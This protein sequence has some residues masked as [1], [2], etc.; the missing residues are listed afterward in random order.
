MT[1]KHTTSGDY[2]GQVGRPF[3]ARRIAQFHDVLA[4][5]GQDVLNAAGMELDSRLGS[6]F[7]LIAHRPGLS[8]AA[9]ADE[10]GLSHQLATYRVK[11]LVEAGLV[12]QARDPEDRTRSILQPTD[13]AGA[14]VE[15]LQTVMRQLD[16]AYA[17]LFSE[18]GADL[19]ELAIRA[20]AALTKTPLLERINRVQD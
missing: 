7:S 1:E 4:E 5:Q 6:V 11:K 15:K 14:E 18:L 8:V 3:L 20:R 16:Q 17:E 10:L 2:V 13:K 19:L 12:S 9:L